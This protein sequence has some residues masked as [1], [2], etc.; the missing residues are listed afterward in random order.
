MYTQSTTG[1]LKNASDACFG[2]V[3]FVSAVRKTH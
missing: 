2:N 1:V 3:L